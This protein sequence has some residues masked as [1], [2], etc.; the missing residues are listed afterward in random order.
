MDFEGLIANHGLFGAQRRN[1]REAVW[2]LVR[3]GL[4]D[5]DNERGMYSMPARVKAMFANQNLQTSIAEPRTYEW[6]ELDLSK[7]YNRSL[8]RQTAL[9][10]RNEAVYTVGPH[11]YNK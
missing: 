10:K 9:D 1:I 4:L 2:E 3:D 11:A 8:R 7:L 6:R 5:A